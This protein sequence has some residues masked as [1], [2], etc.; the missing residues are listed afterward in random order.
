MYTQCPECL[1]VYKVEAELLVPACGCLRCSHCGSIFN[2]LGTLA[3][4]LPP[5]PFT[6]LVA[7]A[8]DQDPPVADVAVF[9]P[10]AEE[11]APAEP[12]AP[13]DA[14][15]ETAESAPVGEDFSGLTFTP[16][17]ARSGR[18]RSWRTAAWVTVCL[19]LVL[20]LGAQ[21]AWAKRDSLVA[22]PTFGPVLQTACTMLGCQLPLVA[23]PG[24]LRLMARDVEQ[25]PSVPDGLL[26]T[27]SVH[28]D[29]HYAQ[30]YPVVTIVL[31]DANGQRLAMRRFQ[32][33]DY[34]SDA[35]ARAHG[36]AAGAT[37]A[38]VFEVQDPGQHAVAFAF[39]F[40]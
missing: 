22:D 3:A 17:F 24:Q 15:A 26:I 29:A 20:G 39:S 40:E 21:L 14:L 12:A 28:N 18:R 33:D 32:P 23:A 34:V 8:L 6:R 38:M 7:H 25:H 37:T 19:L 30:P 16:R 5:E 2:A 11:P 36:L 9:R 35:A 4:Q 1:T 31:S 10:R 13:A 27:A